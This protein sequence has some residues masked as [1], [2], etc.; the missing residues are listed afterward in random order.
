MI[1]EYRIKNSLI[2]YASL[3]RITHMVI[4]LRNK[5]DFQHKTLR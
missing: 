3:V 1:L 4:N 5:T 2:K